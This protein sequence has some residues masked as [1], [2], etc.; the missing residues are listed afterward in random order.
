MVGSKNSFASK[1]SEYFID[2]ESRSFG[3]EALLR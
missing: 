2:H 3:I 1:F